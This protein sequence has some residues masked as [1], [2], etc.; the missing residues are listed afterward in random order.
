MLNTICLKN[1]TTTVAIIPMR[2]IAILLCVSAAIFVANLS[3]QTIFTLDNFNS[4]VGG[5]TGTAQLSWVG[6]VTQNAT[7]ITTTGTGVFPTYVG[8]LD[9]NGWGKSGLTINGTGSLVFQLTAQREAGNIATVVS[10]QLEDSLSRTAVA[11][12][13]T[14]LF[15]VGSLSTVS[16]SAFNFPL[17]SF[18]FAHITGW[19]F[20][21]GT[22][23]I[24]A[25]NMS[26]DNLVLAVPEPSTYALLALG[27]GVIVVPLLRRRR[28]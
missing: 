22:T 9:D 2:K 13:N 6:H 26:F 17:G 8:A 14:S 21:G 19:T 5:A 1:S 4:S 10:L 7:S 27:L 3:A 11:S 18:D 28:S 20:G 12:I 24:N 15:A 23:G 25:L 16:S